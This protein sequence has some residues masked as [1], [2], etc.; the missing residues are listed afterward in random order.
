MMI[1]KILTGDQWR[2]FDE[3][4]VFEGAPIDLADGYVHTSTAEQAQE[5]LDKHFAGQTGLMLAALNEADYGDDLKW[6][7]SRGDALFP[8]IFRPLKLSDVKWCR[9]ITDGQ[10]PDLT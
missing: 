2:A 1:Y 4:G 10:L 7:V 8:H 5:T 6:E 9:P 3:S